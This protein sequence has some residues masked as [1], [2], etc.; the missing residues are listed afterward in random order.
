MKTKKER[1]DRRDL[2]IQRVNSSAFARLFMVY[3][4]QN[5]LVKESIESVCSVYCDENATFG[6][7]GDALETLVD[8]LYP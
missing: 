8:L 6:E 5:T 4:S 3:L 2:P 1:K 7:R